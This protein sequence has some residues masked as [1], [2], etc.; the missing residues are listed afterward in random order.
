MPVHSA[1]LLAPTP[2]AALVAMAHA[3]IAKRQLDEV[4]AAEKALE[5]AKA[6]NGINDAL[7]GFGTHGKGKSAVNKDINYSKYN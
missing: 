3:R 7:R 6:V 4:S 1:A 5:R 2:P